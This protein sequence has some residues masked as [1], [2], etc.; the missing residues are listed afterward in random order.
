MKHVWLVE[1]YHRY[2]GCRE[3]L[4]VF[5]SESAAYDFADAYLEDEHGRYSVRITHK[6]VN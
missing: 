6:K 5:S 3:T 2:A 4:Q 1:V